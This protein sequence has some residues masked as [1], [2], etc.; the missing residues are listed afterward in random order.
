MELRRRRAARGGVNVP[1]TEHFYE[2]VLLRFCLHD[3]FCWFY[4]FSFILVK[5]LKKKKK[6]TVC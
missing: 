2:H 1:L 4:V 5:D 6:N 3:E